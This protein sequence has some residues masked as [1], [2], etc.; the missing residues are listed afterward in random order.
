MCIM[1][2]MCVSFLVRSLLLWSLSG[3]LMSYHTSCA[4]T[5]AYTKKICCLP[6]KANWE[7]IPWRKN[8]IFQLFWHATNTYSVFRSE[9]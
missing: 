3:A 2:I 6:Y 5:T 4:Y 9:L 7:T 1:C 8:N